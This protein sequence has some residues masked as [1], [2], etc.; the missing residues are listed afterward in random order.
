MD[1]L[2]IE[3]LEIIFGYLSVSEIIT[4]LKVC[5]LWNEVLYQN[6]ILLAGKDCVLRCSSKMHK[7]K[8]LWKMIQDRQPHSIVLKNGDSVN[9]QLLLKHNPNIQSLSIE[10]PSKH[11]KKI[12]RTLTLFKNLEIV[13]LI[14]TNRNANSPIHDF[15]I[16]WVHHFPKI[17]KLIIGGLGS[18]CDDIMLPSTLTHL[19]IVRHG[20]IP[21]LE[22]IKV[23]LSHLEIVGINDTLF[24]IL[25]LSL[26]NI[27]TLILDNCNCT[28]LEFPPTMIN[29]LKIKGTVSLQIRLEK[30]LVLDKVHL[31]LDRPLP[32]CM[33]PATVTQ[34]SVRGTAAIDPHWFL[35]LSISCQNLVRLDARGYALKDTIASTLC[36]RFPQLR[37]LNILGCVSRLT[38]HIYLIALLQEGK[39]LIKILCDPPATCSIKEIQTL[40][41]NCHISHVDHKLMDISCDL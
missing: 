25:A 27:R 28:K 5:R 13:G 29:Q 6:S 20:F 26:H 16:E 24:E 23:H 4:C 14:F 9:L 10:C 37:Y 11:Y 41:P 1:K 30:S 18:L 19:S 40:F 22:N 2:P 36:M 32:E 8:Q 21:E 31:S 17:R 3:V 7:A 15:S 12:L 38:D 35:A 33:L 34:L 39:N